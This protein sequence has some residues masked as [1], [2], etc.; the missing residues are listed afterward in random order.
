MNVYL[1]GPMRGHDDLNYPAFNAAAE[2]LRATGYFVFNP[3]ES[4]PL[5]AGIR[6]CFAIDV[7]WICAHADAIAMLPGW[8]NSKGAKAELALSEALGHEVIYL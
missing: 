6:E 4:S 7:A 1:S 5:N 8:E 2:Q 3:A